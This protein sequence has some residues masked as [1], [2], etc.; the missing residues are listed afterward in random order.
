MSVSSL[1]SLSLSPSLASLSLSLSLFLS[2]SLSL[3]LSAYFSLSLCL[4][5]RLSQQNYSYPFRKLVRYG[6][7]VH[8]K[9]R[10]QRERRYH[11]VA[12]ERKGEHHG[13]ERDI[14]HLLACPCLE[15]REE[16]R[17]S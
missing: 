2:L 17:A 14:Y 6:G 16:I 1:V 8:S 7:L 3:S 5:P 12:C 4:R 9:R 15:T 10:K 13:K 11:C